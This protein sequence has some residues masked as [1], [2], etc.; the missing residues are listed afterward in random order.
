MYLREHIVGARQCIVVPK[1]QDAKPELR[2]HLR[3]PLV[4]LDLIR[5]L[6]AVELDDQ[7]FLQAHEVGDVSRYAM[8]PPKPHAELRR[9]Q[10]RPQPHFGIGRI[11]A[12]FACVVD[13]PCPTSSR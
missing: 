6:P 2:Q 4:V 8:L 13:H 1:A 11:A 12:Q 3:A 5:V 9:A 10:L 7:A